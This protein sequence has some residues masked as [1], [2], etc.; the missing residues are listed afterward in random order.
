ML[1]GVR[2]NRSNQHSNITLNDIMLSHWQHQNYFFCLKNP[3]NLLQTN[4]QTTLHT[5]C[6]SIIS[7]WRFLTSV[8]SMFEVGLNVISYDKIYLIVA[9]ALSGFKLDLTASLINLNAPILGII[10]QWSISEW[11]LNKGKGI[12]MHMPKGNR[13]HLFLFR[14][15][16]SILIRTLRILLILLHAIKIFKKVKKWIITT[17]QHHR[18]YWPI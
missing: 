3:S 1:Y 15:S 13:L 6:A 16:I 11:F 10:S 5:K 2:S 7:R 14:G 8:W 17:R 12:A 9:M 4:L 18:S